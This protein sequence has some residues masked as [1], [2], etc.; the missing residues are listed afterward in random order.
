M[1]AETRGGGGGGGVRRSRSHDGEF[2]LVLFLG[3]PRRAGSRRT[4]APAAGAGIRAFRRGRRGATCPAPGE[5]GAAT[6]GSRRFKRPAG[7]DGR[8]KA[9]RRAVPSRLPARRRGAPGGRR[10]AQ[11][12]MMSCMSRRDGARVPPPPAHRGLRR[13]LLPPP[14]A[15]GH[16]K[17]SCTACRPL[18]VFWAQHAYVVDSALAAGATCITSGAAPPSNKRPPPPLSALR[19]SPR[20]L[21]SA[22][23][24]SRTRRARPT[25]GGSALR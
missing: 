16:P 10:N 1:H 9:C 19:P 8:R 6:T 23:A 12:A 20:P 21:S 24:S 15:A 25:R 4:R 5:A 18:R 17:S 13:R 22:C 14:G 11:C 2:S 3:E 7:N